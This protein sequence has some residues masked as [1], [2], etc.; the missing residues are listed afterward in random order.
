MKTFKTQYSLGNNQSWGL[1]TTAADVLENLS[2]DATDKEYLKKKQQ[3]KSEAKDKN[4]KA[5]EEQ[6][7]SQQKKK[8][9]KPTF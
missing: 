4:D 3:Q 2:W 1:I 5:R 8:D 7:H 9:F 6:S